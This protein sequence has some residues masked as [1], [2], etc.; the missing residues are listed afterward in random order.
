MD[1]EM[2]AGQIFELTD[3]DGN[4]F[5]FELLD[6]V[7]VDEKLYAVLSTVDENAAD[8]DELNVVIMLTEFESKEPVFTLVEDDDTCNKVIKAFTDLF[9]EDDKDT[10]NEMI[11]E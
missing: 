3:E 8:E 6:F 4:A 11:T 2:K 10:D 5:T 1:N 9:D 7:V